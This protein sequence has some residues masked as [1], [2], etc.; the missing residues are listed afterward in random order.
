MAI[1]IT[2]GP[3]TVPGSGGGG[4]ALSV[5]TIA[6]IDSAVGVSLI[7]MLL[8]NSVPIGPALLMIG[9]TD[10]SIG[11]AVPGTPV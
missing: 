10:V 7:G 6:S 1:T 4:E 11:H 8:D 2:V 9:A 3:T 5:A